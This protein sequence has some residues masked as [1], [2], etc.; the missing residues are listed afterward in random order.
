MSLEIVQKKILAACQRA[1]R[2][3]K[4][5][6]L[7]AVSKGRSLAEIQNLLTRAQFPL[8]ENRVPEANEKMLALPNIPFHFIGHL[9]RNKAKFCKNFALIHSLDSLRLAEELARLGETWGRVPPVLLEINASQEEQKHGVNPKDAKELLHQTQA[10]GL[11][12]R[13]LMGMG[14]Q[15]DLAATRQVFKDLR[16]LRDNLGPMELSIGMS[17]DFE[18]AIEEGATMLRIGRALWTSDGETGDAT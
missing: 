8:G 3:P 7:I 15:D 9:Q 14:V 5:L 1:G 16:A 2:N 17:D 13:G 18:I 6:Q 4:D 10:L 11:D 12:V